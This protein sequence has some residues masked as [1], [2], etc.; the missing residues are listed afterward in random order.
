M[1]VAAFIVGA[2]VLLLAGGFIGYGLA[3]IVISEDE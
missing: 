1:I 3:M 2:V